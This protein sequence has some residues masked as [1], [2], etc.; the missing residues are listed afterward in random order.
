MPFLELL[1][2][3]NLRKVYESYLADKL[4]LFMSFFYILG[5]EYG[6]SFEFI[7]EFYSQE[8]PISLLNKSININN[9]ELFTKG[10]L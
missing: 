5:I 10:K 3:K 8:T 7:L 6:K 4:L 1:E 9:L 2:S